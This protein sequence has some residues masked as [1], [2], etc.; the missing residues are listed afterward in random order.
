M[1]EH[2]GDFRVYFDSA[3]VISVELAQT[4]VGAVEFVTDPRYI[5][6]ATQG[7]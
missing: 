5:S 6:A 1:R 7:I 2:G 4:C 3:L